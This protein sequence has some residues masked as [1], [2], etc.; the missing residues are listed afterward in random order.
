MPQT[1]VMAWLHR[2]IGDLPKVTAHPH[3]LGGTEYQLGDVTLGYID[4]CGI[5]DLDTGPELAG[6]LTIDLSR[7]EGGTVALWL[8]CRNYRL[9]ASPNGATGDASF[10]APDIAPSILLLDGAGTSSLR[11]NPPGP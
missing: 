11:S 9:A 1:D 7:P 4:Q 2:A 10:E 5:V 8:L 3:P 6:R